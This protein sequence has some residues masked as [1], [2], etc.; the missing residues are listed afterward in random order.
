MMSQ[1]IL[2]IIAVVL[3]LH[4][5]IHLMG[6]TAYWQLAEIK[7]LPYKTTLLNGRLH[8]GDAGMRV[9]GLVWLVM[10][11]AFAVTA[12]GIVTHQPWARPA[13][14]AT[15]LVSLLVTALDWQVAYAGVV[16][17]LVLLLAFWF[18]PRLAGN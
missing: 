13:A 4:G 10:T 17:N 6:F 18:V 8:I 2:V 14:L 9:Y 5:L 1:I 15:V 11:A 16:I 7:E 3:L 12:Y